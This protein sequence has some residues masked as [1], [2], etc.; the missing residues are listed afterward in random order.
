MLKR[1]HDSQRLRTRLPERP[2]MPEVADLYRMMDE[3][4]RQ[5]GRIMEQ[6]WFRLETFESFSLTVEFEPGQK[7]PIWTLYQA[8]DD[9]NRLLWSCRDAD[10]YL[11]HDILSMFTS[12]AAPRPAAPAPGGGPAAASEAAPRDKTL[13]VDTPAV[14]DEFPGQWRRRPEPPAEGE[15][16]LSS[17]R[18][19]DRW[20]SRPA[21]EDQAV[22][23]AA[24]EA[25][26][27]ARQE[28]PELSQP[29]PLAPDTYDR[30]ARE[31][32]AGECGQTAPADKADASG[33]AGVKDAEP[34]P[35]AAPPARPD[36]GGDSQERGYFESLAPEEFERLKAQPNVL[37]GHLLVE[38]GAIPEALLDAALKLQ[39]MVRSE[40]LTAVQSV[41]AMR[42]AHKRVQ[43]EA[44]LSE[45]KGQSATDSSEGKLV[46]ELLFEAGLVTRADIDA[47]TKLKVRPGGELDTLRAAGKLDKRTQEAAIKCFRMMRDRLIRHEQAVI[48]LNYAHRMRVSL[49]EAFQDLDWL[50]PFPT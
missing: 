11:L 17:A 16:V 21:A 49:R 28:A 46:T 23:Q 31:P 36:S 50:Y 29:A 15:G 10:V 19:I 4:G 24:P 33:Q 30:Q 13:P 3:A 9:N 32:F 38:C 27:P 45:G 18:E 14:E 12:Q 47:A 25:P 34:L 43:D 7:T 8:L 22:P 44:G 35:R 1:D 41:D 40:S 42:R 26:A 6:P 2:T 48:A 39:E 5:A 20:T 37:L